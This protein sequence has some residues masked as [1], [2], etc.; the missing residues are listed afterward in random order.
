VH[1]IAYPLRRDGVKLPK[2]EVRAGGK[3]GWLTFARM[4][5][6]QPV[7]TA[8]LTTSGGASILPDLECAN[9]RHV[10]RGLLIQGLVR[11]APRAGTGHVRQAWWCVPDP[12]AEGSSPEVLP[13]QGRR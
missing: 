10:E 7:W 1:C 3:H 6:G 12:A 8:R 9:V 4:P 11:Q 2:N 13:T 5:A